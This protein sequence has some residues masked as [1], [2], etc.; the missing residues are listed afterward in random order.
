MAGPLSC[1]NR[2]TA[3]GAGASRV[4]AATRRSRA[5]APAAS[6]AGRAAAAASAHQVPVGVGDHVGH[7]GAVDGQAGGQL[8]HR[9]PVGRLVAGQMPGHPGDLGPEVAGQPLPLAGKGHGGRVGVVAGEPAVALGEGPGGRPVDQ[10]PVGDGQELV[11]GGAGDRPGGQALAV[12]EDLLDDHERH[13][14]GQPPQVGGRV[15]QAVDVVDPDPVDQALGDQPEDGGVGAQVDLGV[16]LA[17]PDE[18][19][20]GEEAAVVEVDRGPAPL[21]QLVVLRASRSVPGAVGKRCS[22]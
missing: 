10:H 21:D 19:V 5:A 1:W 22:W 18:V 7:I 12:L 17:D 3:S 15:G 4:R 11:P 2:R 16:L 9:G 14:G 13:L 6:S 20:D 8:G